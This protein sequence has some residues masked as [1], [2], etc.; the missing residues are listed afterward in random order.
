LKVKG[1]VLKN[2]SQI[3]IRLL[4]DLHSIAHTP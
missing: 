4:G 1:N 3:G 2:A